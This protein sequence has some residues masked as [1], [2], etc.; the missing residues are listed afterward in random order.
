[1]NQE[2]IDFLGRQGLSSDAR[3]F[4]NSAEELRNAQAA[5]TLTPRMQRGFCTI[6]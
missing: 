1:M 2:W 6:C 3:D 4:G 5:T